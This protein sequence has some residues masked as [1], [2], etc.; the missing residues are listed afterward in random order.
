MQRMELWYAEQCLNDLNLQYT[1]MCLLACF[2]VV[3]M[4][5]EFGLSLT[6]D[7]FL[8]TAFMVSLAKK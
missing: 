8:A 2:P 1:N 3:C 6:Q 7:G 5:G 4:Q